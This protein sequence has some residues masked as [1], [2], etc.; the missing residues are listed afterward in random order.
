MKAKKLEDVKYNITHSNEDLQ[1]SLVWKEG[2]MFISVANLLLRDGETWYDIPVKDLR[3][4]QIVS[5]EPL[6]LR[7]KLRFLD[8]N[9]SGE[10]ANRLLALR[11]FLLSYINGEGEGEEDAKELLKFWS[12]GITNPDALAILLE[13]EKEEVEDLLAEVMSKGYLN[14]EGSITQKGLDLF[15]EEDREMLQRGGRCE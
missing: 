8:V 9:V 11:H 6:Q 5:E 15:P 10:R 2:E 4:V 7:F 12:V 13:T 14:E 3:N 1:L